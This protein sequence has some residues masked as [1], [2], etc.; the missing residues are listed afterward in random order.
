MKAKGNMFIELIWVFAVS[1]LALIGYLTTGF[2]CLCVLSD[3]DRSGPSFVDRDEAVPWL[4]TSW[5]I[6]FPV[7]LVMVFWRNRKLKRRGGR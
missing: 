4:A 3:M 7:L 1:G 6:F 5:P 2:I